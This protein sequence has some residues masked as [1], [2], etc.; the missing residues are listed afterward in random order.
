MRCLNDYIQSQEIS[1]NQCVNCGLQKL[2][3]CFKAR[4]NLISR[5]DIFLMH[6]FPPLPRYWGILISKDQNIFMVLL[7]YLAKAVLLPGSHGCSSEKGLGAFQL[8]LDL[9]PLN[10]GTTSHPSHH[11]CAQECPVVFLKTNFCVSIYRYT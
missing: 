4:L 9:L 5:P 3:L 2:P 11:F 6:V 1:C 10:S 8:L 7:T